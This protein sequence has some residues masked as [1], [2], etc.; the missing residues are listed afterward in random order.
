ML[1]LPGAN[2]VRGMFI[3]TVAQDSRW[4]GLITKSQVGNVTE[5][6]LTDTYNIFKLFD[7]SSNYFMGWEFFYPNS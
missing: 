1:Q 2:R 6:R 3:F 5:N 7:L 4:S